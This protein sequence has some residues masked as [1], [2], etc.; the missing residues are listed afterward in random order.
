MTGTAGVRKGFTAGAPSSS[1]FSAQGTQVNPPILSPALANVSAV[2]FVTKAGY[3]FM[4]FLPDNVSPAQFVNE[5]VAS[6]GAV[7]T[8]GGSP[9]GTKIGTDMSETNWCAYAHRPATSCS[10]RTR[11]PSRTA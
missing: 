2:G 11:R 4:I 7:P 8:L 10:P 5:K 3:A 6:A 1:D 9:G